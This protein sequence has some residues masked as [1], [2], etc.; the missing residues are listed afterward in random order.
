MPLATAVADPDDV[1]IVATAV[2][3]ELQVAEVVISFVVLSE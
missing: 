2:L 1:P 3:S